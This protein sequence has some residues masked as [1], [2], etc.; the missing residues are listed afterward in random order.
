MNRLTRQTDA[1]RCLFQNRVSAIAVRNVSVVVLGTSRRTQMVRVIRVRLRISVVG[2][3]V[4]S[5]RRRSKERCRRRD[6]ERCW[7]RQ[8]SVSAG[9]SLPA[10]R[11]RRLQV[12]R[13][14]KCGYRVR[15]WV[16]F[17]L[18]DVLCCHVGNR[19]FESDCSVSNQFKSE[20]PRQRKK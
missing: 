11:S 12:Q 15:C 1:I 9:R 3:G 6:L 16:R 5:T 18:V 17:G 4:T 10:R 8:E 20:N 7:R 13:I 2:S 19:G 14:K